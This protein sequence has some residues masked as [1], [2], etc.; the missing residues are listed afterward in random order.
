[1]DNPISGSERALARQLTQN[2]C[3]ES[4]APTAVDP[5]PCEAYAGCKAGYPVHWC[6]TSGNAHGRQDSLAP[7]AFWNFFKSL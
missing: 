1:M 7:S 6:E 2:M 4:A 3:D 5:A